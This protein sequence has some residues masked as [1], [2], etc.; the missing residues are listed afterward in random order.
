M[1][2]CMCVCV[3][4]C[5][6]VS[7]CMR[8]C[9][10]WWG[11]M[12][13]KSYQQKVCRQM[14]N[15]KKKPLPGGVPQHLS[16][17]PAAATTGKHS[18]SRVTWL[19]RM[20]HELTF[21]KFFPPAAPAD[22]LTPKISGSAIGGVGVGVNAVAAQQ[23]QLLRYVCVWCDSFICGMLIHVW[24]D[25]LCDIIISRMNVA[26]MAGWRSSYVSLL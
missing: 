5:V 13:C 24:Y 6:C 21:A 14:E 3:C 11:Q 10:V 12:V 19:I 23:T 18:H 4:L 16:T 8:V 1:Y 25:S 9:I 20:W 2:V 15:L 17:V 22:L 7:V 26:Y